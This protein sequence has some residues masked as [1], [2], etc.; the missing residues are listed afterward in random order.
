[1]TCFKLLW[2]TETVEK[3]PVS[4]SDQST[5][6]P[7]EP[8]VPP[9]PPLPIMSKPL[10]PV[11]N[12]TPPAGNVLGTPVENNLPSSLEPIPNGLKIWKP[13]LAVVL[14]LILG[15]GGYLFWTLYWHNP[16]RVLAASAQK[17]TSAQSVHVE[18]GFPELSNQFTLDLHRDFT[19]YSHLK[20]VMSNL[21][22]DTKENLSGEAIVNQDNLYSILTYSRLAEVATELEQYYPGV[23]QLQTYQLLNPVLSGQ[24]WLH[25]D[26]AEISKTLN[27]SASLTP[28]ATPTPS[29][30]TKDEQELEQ[31]LTDSVIIRQN[32]FGFEFE[33]QKY[34]RLAIG[35][36]RDK[37]IQFL[38]KAKSMPIDVKVSDINSLEKIINSADNWDADLIVLLIDSKGYPYQAEVSMP[39]IPESVLKNEVGTGTSGNAVAGGVAQE[40]LNSTSGFF[41][42]QQKGQLTKILTVRLTNYN[43]VPE[44]TPPTNVVEAKELMT[45]AQVELAPIVQQMMFGSSA[46]AA[47]SNSV[48]GA[49][50]VDFLPLLQP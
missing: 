15:V 49:K 25:V 45:V 10:N 33:G 7:S 8:T 29:I 26:F 12:S 17:M 35:F 37:L 20:F 28:K 40:I 23:T 47:S 24:K 31:I 1:L 14:L 11:I 16:S 43:Q 5:S 41:N 36:R 39:Q 21:G 18:A 50:I 22:G 32:N 27:E 6:V 13:I 2:H 34:T 44:V 3:I 19:Q 30:S 46:P 38:E 48:L 9:P 42:K 4:N